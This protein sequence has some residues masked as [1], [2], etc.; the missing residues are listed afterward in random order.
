MDTFD[1]SVMYRFNGH[2]YG[3]QMGEDVMVS[4]TTNLTWTIEQFRH[5]LEYKLAWIDTATTIDGFTK[6]PWRWLTEYELTSTQGQAVI[7]GDEEGM[8]MCSIN[9]QVNRNL[10]AAAP[11]M[12]EDMNRAIQ[13]IQE[14]DYECAT[15]ILRDSQLY[16]RGGK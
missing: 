11:V 3:L 2:L 1:L 5:F 4:P 6:G 7:H 14:R 10:I 16:A 15:H 13:C 8:H 9:E 12:Y